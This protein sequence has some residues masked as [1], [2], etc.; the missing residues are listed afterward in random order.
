[1]IGRKE[2]EHREERECHRCHNHSSKACISGHNAHFFRDSSED[3]MSQTDQITDT[4]YVTEGTYNLSLDHTASQVHQVNPYV[5]TVDVEGIP[6]SME[7][8]IGASSTIFSQWA[9]HCTCT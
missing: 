5:C 7:I 3:S 8:D 6:V 9:A 2:V 1:M 4:R